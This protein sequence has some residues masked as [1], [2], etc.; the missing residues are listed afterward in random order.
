MTDPDAALLDR[1]W[2]LRVHVKG[3]WALPLSRPLP[4]VG[5]PRCE[6]GLIKPWH[7][8]LFQLAMCATDQDTIHHMPHL[9]PS[10]I[11]LP[12]S[13]DNA[14]ELVCVCV[15]SFSSLVI[16]KAVKVDSHWSTL[17]EYCF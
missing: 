13:G 5:T 2:I 4:V 10:L 8:H 9:C 7:A 6:A 17:Y 15:Q 1:S 11:S 12:S 3:Y 14:L 16:L